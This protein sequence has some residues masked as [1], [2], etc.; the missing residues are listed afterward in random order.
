MTRPIETYCTANGVYHDSVK[1]EVDTW[2]GCVETRT[3]PAEDAGCEVTRVWLEDQGCI[4]STMSGAEEKELNQRIYEML[5]QDA[6][7]RYH[8]AAD[9]AYEQMKDRELGL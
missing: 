5:C 8:D 1:V 7:D 6:E 4:L 9:H 3:D 2:E